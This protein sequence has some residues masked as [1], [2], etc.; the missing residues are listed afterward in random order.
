MGEKGDEATGDIHSTRVRYISFM[1]TWMKALVICS[2]R[3]SPV[4]KMVL[5]I[6]RH[7]Q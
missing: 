3:N 2:I 5:R 7:N 6:G 4:K 1:M